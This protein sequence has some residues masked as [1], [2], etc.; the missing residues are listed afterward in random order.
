MYKVKNNASAIKIFFLQKL[1]T[2]IVL[3]F[4]KKYYGSINID[5]EQKKWDR[6]ECKYIRPSDVFCRCDAQIRFYTLV[7]FF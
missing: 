1:N 3:S 5:L 7:Q 4:V 2:L 6:P